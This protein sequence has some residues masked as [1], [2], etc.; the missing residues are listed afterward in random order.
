MHFNHFSETFVKWMMCVFKSLFQDISRLKNTDFW[1]SGRREVTPI[2]WLLA[3]HWPITWNW[4][5]ALSRVW[6]STGWLWRRSQSPGDWEF[7]AQCIDVKLRLKNERGS[8]SGLWSFPAFSDST[9]RKQ[10]NVL[11]VSNIGFGPEKES[12]DSYWLKSALWAIDM[13]GKS[14]LESY[15]LLIIEGRFLFFSDAI[16]KY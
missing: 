8:G 12:I 1:V 6:S 11:R 10:S 4:S 2:D 16:V 14:S 13:L 9:I 5:S 15:S 3:L 7:S